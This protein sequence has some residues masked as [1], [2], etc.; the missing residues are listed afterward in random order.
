MIDY[1]REID[2]LRAVSVISVILFHA[3]F[4]MFSGGFVGVDIFFVIS[5]FLISRI[6]YTEICKEE[7]SIVDFY[8]RRA[9]R[10]LPALLFV[11]L[12][13]LPLAWLYL[14]PNYFIDF[15]QSIISTIFFSDL[16]QI[17]PTLQYQTQ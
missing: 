3:K 13:C 7:F 11:I 2:G 6:I 1:R 15:S 14:T 16:C 8:D 4:E 9:R 5:G 12:A 10:I 17:H